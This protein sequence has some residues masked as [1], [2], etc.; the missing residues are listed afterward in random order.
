VGRIRPIYL[1]HNATTPL[2]PAVGDAIA[3][4]TQL[5]F[6][7]PS[8]PHS[9]GRQ[10]R[11]L[12]DEA[13]ERLAALWQCRPS[14]IIFT[15]GGTEA[16]NL[17]ILAAAR[18]R[19]GQGRHLVTSSVEHPSIREPLRYLA[20]REG[21]EV[22]IVR[23]DPQ[24]WVDPDDVLAACRPDTIL[25]SVMAANNEIGTLQPVAEIGRRCQERGLLFHTD[26]AQWFAKEPV[27]GIATFSADL[28]SGCAHKLHGPKGAGVLY[29][30]SPLVLEPVLLGGSQEHDRRAGTENLP[31]ILGLVTA[32]ERFTPT[33]VFSRPTLD[34]LCQAL[35]DACTA[36]PGVRRR[37][38]PLP[39]R[40]A[41]TLAVTVESCDSLSLLAGLDLEGVCASSGSACSAGAL[42]PSQTLLGL[43]A[44][45]E[46]ARSLVRFSLGRET[47][48]HDVALTAAAFAE[49]V[50][51]VRNLAKP[52]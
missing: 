34:P 45:P 4:A 52:G 49:V 47:T 6:A 22:S 15:S 50:R 28:V 12:L 42:E 2:D 26:A 46:E 5:G 29:A 24:G 21:F 20:R 7:N 40:L 11:V 35:E 9:L 17:A 18:T 33:P 39:G 41:N 37:G 48:R 3:A 13:R 32:W 31:A 19:S 8:S 14:E 23:T 30:R 27:Q 25:V 36:L 44:T 16:N 43:G 38:P 1:D 51:R 10:A